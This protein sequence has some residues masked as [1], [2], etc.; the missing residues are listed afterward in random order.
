MNETE[1]GTRVP[2]VV[3]V[4]GAS[5]FLGGYL[6]TR[7][8]HDPRIDRVL[9]VDSV[10]PSK[11]MRRRMGRAEFVRAD[12]RNPLIG[13]VIRSEAVDTVVHTGLHTRAV[14]AGGRAVMKEVNVIG[15]MHLFAACQKSPQ[16]RR[17]VVRSSSAVYGNS[18]TDP[19]RF[20]E[21]MTSKNPPRGGFPKDC[22]EI[23][24][25]ARGAGRRRDDLDVAILRFAPVIG[26]RMDTQLARYFAT[27]VVPS[28]LGRDPRL[29][30]L[31]EEDA[32]G[33]LER[34][35]MTCVRGTF[36]IGADGTVS[37]SQ[38][39]RRAGRV[40]LPLPGMLFHR[41]GGLL[42][43]VRMAD[44]TSEEVSYLNYGLG[45]DTTRMRTELGF[46][47]RWTTVQAFDD[48][49]RG[50]ALSP[51]IDPQSVQTME[52]KVV[53]AARRLA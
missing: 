12:L 46:R 50:R 6:A 24:G 37:A 9:A 44:F 23:E 21:E 10:P 2:K 17:L 20:T 22:A 32:L 15:A 38:A 47:P 31:H 45:L 28:I 19:A 14:E 3:L 27:P 52:R 48:F 36:N 18:A 30:L 16:V 8:T 4:T 35:T 5:K 1:S 39:I 53:G 40:E 51:V 7:L 33:A 42:R 13:K 11:D 43:G 26:S 49:V 29:Q 41:L 34:A 25:Y